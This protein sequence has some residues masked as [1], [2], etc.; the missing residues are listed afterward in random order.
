VEFVDDP[1]IDLAVISAILSSNEDIAL[2]PK[3]CFAA[4][5]G[6]SGELRPV[7]RLEQR[8]SEAQ[9]LGYEEIVI[10][11]HSKLGKEKFT[12]K[13]ISCGKVEE[14]FQHLFG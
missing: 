7:A 2:S 8:I 5:V 3:L 1:A 11:S 14:V 6:L 12:I 10:S 9:K 4:E 13:L